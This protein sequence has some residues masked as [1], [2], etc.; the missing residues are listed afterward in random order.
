MENRKFLSTLGLCK[1]AGQLIIGF[2]PVA[3][4]IKAGKVKL[5]LL[6]SDLSPKSAKEIIRIAKM[7]NIDILQMPAAMDEI[8]R[9]LGKRAGILAITGE[10]LAQVLKTSIARQEEENN[11]C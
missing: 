10:G 3:E 7:H 8:M 9:L 5:L 4:A 1:K 11:I 6:A 2:D